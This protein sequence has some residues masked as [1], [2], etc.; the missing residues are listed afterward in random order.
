MSKSLVTASFSPGSQRRGG[1]PARAQTAPARLSFGG[2]GGWEAPYGR[3]CWRDVRFGGRE[4]GPSE[5]GGSGFQGLEQRARSREEGVE[6]R[7]LRSRPAGCPRP[8]VPQRARL[9]HGGSGDAP[10][11][12][13]RR[14]PPGLWVIPA[15]L[16]GSS[17]GSMFWRML[18]IDRGLSKV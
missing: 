8:R 15:L 10:A 18:M 14:P 2:R 3:G 6:A 13:A 17:L 7:P 11:S 12:D 1:Q 16:H 5:K 4:R 9:P